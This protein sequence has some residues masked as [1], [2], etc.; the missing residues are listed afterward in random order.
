MHFV[1]LSSLRTGPNS[2]TV[3]FQF[4]TRDEK[5]TGQND[6]A[7]L[8][9]TQ[10]RACA[11]FRFTDSEPVRRLTAHL[12]IRHLQQQAPLCQLCS[13]TG[14]GACCSHTGGRS[15]RKL[16][17]SRWRAVDI[18]LQILKDVYWLWLEAACG[19]MLADD[20]CCQRRVFLKLIKAHFAP[21][22]RFWC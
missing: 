20:E 8:R 12:A 2:S 14:S 10:I 22:C 17:V 1:I 3:L 16:K 13:I 15:P 7:N 5:G 9:A 4:G 18:I 6:L 11:Q 21:N 19:Q